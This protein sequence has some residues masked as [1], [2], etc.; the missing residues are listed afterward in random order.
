MNM[1]EYQTA[2]HKTS[3][4]ER[5]HIQHA[6][7]GLVAEVGEIA[8]NYQRYF[9][10]DFGYGTVRSNLHKELGDVL[11]YLAE[12]ATVHEFTLDTIARANLAKLA[13]REA[14]NTIKGSGEER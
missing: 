9:R 13:S 1:N 8:G 11:W 10:G 2:A 12:L 7:H 3:Q 14:N 6:I 5:D 4:P